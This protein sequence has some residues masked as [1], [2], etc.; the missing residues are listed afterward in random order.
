M[1]PEQ[2]DDLQSLVIDGLE[3]IT[4]GTE[5]SLRAVFESPNECD[6]NFENANVVDGLFAVARAIHHLAE[7]LE[8]K[9]R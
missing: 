4:K 7:V 1:D 5:R 3:T 8:D 2:F 9:R 6:S